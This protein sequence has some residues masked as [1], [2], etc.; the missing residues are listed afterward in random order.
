MKMELKCVCYCITRNLYQ[1]VQPSVHSMI[2]KGNPDGL[3]I[4][5]EDDNIGM[6]LPDWAEVINMS[7]QE[8]FR[9]DGPNYHKKWTYMAMMKTTMAKIFPDLQR[10]LTLDH[11]TLILGDLSEL[12]GIPMYENY[13]AGCNEP[14][15]ERITGRKYINAGVLMWNLDKIRED[16]MDDKMIGMLNEI[17]FQLPEQHVINRACMDHIQV[18]D[19]AYNFC[20]YVDTP[21]QPV[22][23][24]HFAGQAGRESWMRKEIWG[25]KNE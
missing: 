14:Y 17:D 22:K 7:R 1:A 12:W 18:L 9:S 25:D 21:C 10:I 8:F 11:D 3:F 5:A 6:Q 24:L 4:L 23:I 13:V 16:K 20:D 2:R 19:S 15:W